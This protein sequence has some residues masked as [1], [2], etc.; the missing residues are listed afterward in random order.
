MRVIDR[1]KELMRVK[2]SEIKD[3]PKNCR[4]HPNKQ[5][6]A[7]VAMIE[8]IGYADALVARR[9][10]DGSLELID[11]HLRKDCTP[12]QEVP[13]I[14]V[15]LNDEETAK[16]LVVLDNITA[17]AETDGE[18]LAELSALVDTQS[19]ELR[20]LLDE[21]CGAM[22]PAEIDVPTLNLVVVKCLSKFDAEDLVRKLVAE[23]FKCK[24]EVQM[25]SRGV[26]ENRDHET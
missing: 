17:M 10:P 25:D 22:L 2:A 3:N 24:M 19:E 14:I 21:N 1:V 7:M 15:D 16:L 5:R 8:E 11:G 23:G 18:K 26:I 4:I 6:R 20:K 9:L 12:D 13:V